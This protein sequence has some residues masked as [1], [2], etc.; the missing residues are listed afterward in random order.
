MNATVGLIVI[1]ACCGAALYAG[2]RVLAG[3]TGPWP[4]VSG[5]ALGTVVFCWVAGGCLSWWS[6]HPP[7]RPGV[8]VGYAATVVLLSG[9]GLRWATA[10]SGRSG[11]LIRAA[12]CT[13]LA[14]LAWR[15]EQVWLIPVR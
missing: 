9:V 12:T 7:A 15:T 5:I 1:I 6:G 8:F 11:D 4:D 2:K 13:L 14:F 10:C 3:P